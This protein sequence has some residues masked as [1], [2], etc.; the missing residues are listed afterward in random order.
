MLIHLPP[1]LEAT[2]HARDVL[3]AVF[4][5]ISG[6]A[7]AAVAV[8]AVNH[9]HGTLVGVLDEFPHVAIVQMPRGVPVGTLAIGRAGAI[10]AA[11]LAAAIVARGDD[12]VRERL[13]AYRESQTEAVLAAPDPSA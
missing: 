2:A 4:E 8:V 6:G 9:D 10:N 12:A 13:A 1:S 3:E 11:L 5:E 7:Q